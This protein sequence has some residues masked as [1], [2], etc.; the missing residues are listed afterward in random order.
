MYIQIRNYFRYNIVIRGRSNVPME[1][2]M[3]FNS[4]AKFNRS[5]IFAGIAIFSENTLGCLQNS[6]LSG[7]PS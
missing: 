6:E 7:Y 5:D 1:S 3:S 4:D 2:H